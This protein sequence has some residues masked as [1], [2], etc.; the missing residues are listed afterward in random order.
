MEGNWSRPPA[1]QSR[2]RESGHR[3]GERIRSQSAYDVGLGAA[4]TSSTR[5]GSEGGCYDVVKHCC[6]NSR[7]ERFLSVSLHPHAA[8]V[9]ILLKEKSLFHNCRI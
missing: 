8:S 4:A 7:N 5:E 6:C 9:W 1:Q 3:W 2:V